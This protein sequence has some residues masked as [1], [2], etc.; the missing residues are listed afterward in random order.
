MVVLLLLQGDKNSLFFSFTFDYDLHGYRTV[1]NIPNV[2]FQIPSFGWSSWMNN[3]CLHPKWNGSFQVKK[4][5]LEIVSE[6]K[7]YN[8]ANTFSAWCLSKKE[9]C[10]CLLGHF[11]KYSFSDTCHLRN[12]SEF[13]IW[14]PTSFIL[15]Q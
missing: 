6:W 5:S 11:I 12:T 9:S 10:G 13:V 3:S 8:S 14:L 2:S 7:M 1:E 4:W 15:M